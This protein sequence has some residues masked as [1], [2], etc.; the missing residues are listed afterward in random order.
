MRNSWRE[1]SWERF[2]MRKRDEDFIVSALKDALGAAQMSRAHFDDLSDPAEIVI[3]K[4]RVT[5]FI[6]ERTRV[7]RQSW[8]EGPVQ[9]V[10]NRF[11]E[12]DPE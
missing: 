9:A 6:Q 11:E 2:S 8:I 1:R 7:Y 12:Q 10:L 5:A 3:P 4:G